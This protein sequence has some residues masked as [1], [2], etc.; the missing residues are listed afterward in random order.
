MHNGRFHQTVRCIYGY[1]PPGGTVNSNH[2]FSAYARRFLNSAHSSFLAQTVRTAF[3]VNR[4]K[5]F[6]VVLLRRNFFCRYITYCHYLYLKIL[7]IFRFQ[8]FSK[9]KSK[10]LSMSSLEKLYL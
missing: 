2:L 5:N 6:G 7:M 9:N 10:L 4:S 3:E 1:D 8:F